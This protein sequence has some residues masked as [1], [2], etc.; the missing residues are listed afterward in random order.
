MCQW[1]LVQ[2][3]LVTW[4]WVEARSYSDLTLLPYFL[5]GLLQLQ[6]SGTS[7][8]EDLFLSWCKGCSH[9]CILCKEYNGQENNINSKLT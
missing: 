6:Q 4:L 5:Q 1:R 8:E 7:V 3:G 2:Q 9:C